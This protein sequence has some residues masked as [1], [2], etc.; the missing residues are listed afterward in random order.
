MSRHFLILLASFALVACNRNSDEEFDL[1]RSFTID[2]QNPQLHAL[3]WALETC[4]IWGTQPNIAGACSKRQD[5]ARHL[6]DGVVTCQRRENFGYIAC[7]RVE[8]WASSKSHDLTQIEKLSGSTG[9]VE[10]LASLREL[11]RPSNPFIG[12]LWTSDDR[13]LALRLG[14]W[15]ELAATLIGLIVVAASIRRLRSGAQLRSATL[16]EAPLAI[17]LPAPE[18]VSEAIPST[19]I[20]AEAAPGPLPKSEDVSNESVV[21]NIEVEREISA[22]RA[23]EIASK[24]AKAV[25]R[26][27]AAEAAQREFDQVKGLF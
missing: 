1:V 18:P 6:L 15:K 21:E 23:A 20:R 24:E 14:A 10:D 8:K 26:R 2:W 22:E 16:T 9:R 3:T 13:W 27:A 25:A 17:P 7:V 11:A 19:N 12:A 5:E 4:A